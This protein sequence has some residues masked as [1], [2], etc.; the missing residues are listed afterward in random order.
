LGRRGGGGE[1]LAGRKKK[2]ESKGCG[3]EGCV[4][5]V[6]I[7]RCARLSLPHPAAAKQT[8]REWGGRREWRWTEESPTAASV[9]LT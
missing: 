1:L 2:K 5:T 6:F 4:M 3:E 9:A 8:R 7:E